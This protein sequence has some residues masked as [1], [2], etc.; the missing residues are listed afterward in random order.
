M[1]SHVV[2]LAVRVSGL[3]A[4]KVVCKAPA[5]E[6]PAKEQPKAADEEDEQH[7]VDYWVSGLEF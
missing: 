3:R 4:L 7:G 2:C 6:E 5:K 1:R